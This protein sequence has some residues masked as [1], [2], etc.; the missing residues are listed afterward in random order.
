MKKQ[1]KALLI[2]A[3]RLLSYP[4]E[5]VPKQE[6]QEIVFD[7][8]QS[9]S[10]QQDMMDACQPLFRLPLGEIQQLYVQTFDLQANAGLY[11]TA[12][13][14]GDSH[15]R[16]AALIKLQKMVNEAG[17]ER[18]EGELADY[19][20]MLFEFL[21][22]SPDTKEKERLR[23]RLSAACYRI[24]KHIDAD[25]PY[26]GILQVLMTY[27]FAKPSAAELRKLENGREEADLEELP[28]PIMYQ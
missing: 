27:V 25:N 24:F 18:V 10:L 17:F 8:M 26:Y 5:R 22:V 20:P 9:K 28:Y 15:K 12:H 14:L 7:T 3:S 4:E 6:I 2:I 16:G 23:K 11:L 21:T 1:T 13:E 19:I